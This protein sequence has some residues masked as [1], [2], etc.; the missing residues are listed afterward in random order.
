MGYKELAKI[1]E[2]R[3][4]SR[5]FEDK[6]PSV[7]DM[8]KEYGVS[9]VTA[10]R[11][12]KVLKA[13]GLVHTIPG[14]G[15]IPARV[16]RQRTRLLGA[17]LATNNLVGAPLHNS[18]YM[19]M[20]NAANKNHHTICL[21]EGT[22]GDEGLEIS[23]IKYLIEDRDVDGI[24]LWPNAYFESISQGAQFLKDEHIPHVIIPEPN[25]DIYQDYNC[26][27][28]NN[29]SSASSVMKELIALGH[30]KIACCVLKDSVNSNHA[31]ERT[32]S[33]K[34]AMSDAGYPVLE[35]I[36]LNHKEGKDDMT[37]G[38]KLKDVDAVFC[39]DDTSAMNLLR[40]CLKSGI[41]IPV[42]LSIYSF[43]NYPNSETLGISSVDLN[44]DKIGYH[45]VQILV[46][47]IE[48]QNKTVQHKVIEPQLFSRS[49]SQKN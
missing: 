8:S 17:V 28:S 43:N 35:T 44:F 48:G 12:V 5:E 7:L 34:K 2:K 24:I 15:I 37:T 38:N 40:V 41:R 23:Q 25:L 18:L 21:S 36:L 20:Q 11:A 14:T 13:Q 49:S 30:K 45:A 19:G 6:M 29:E 39:I 31:L 46:N 33:Y 9:L 26:V 42:D 3:I 4:F 10:Q 47:E 22:H 16:K 1:L 27:C 32:L